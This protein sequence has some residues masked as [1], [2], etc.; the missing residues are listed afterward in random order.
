MFFTRI[1][2]R[3]FTFPSLAGV[4]QLWGRI[5]VLREPSRKP[6]CSLLESLLGRSLFRAWLGSASSG[7][8]FL[9]S[10]NPL[11]NHC[12]LQHTPY[13]D[14]HFSKP[15]WGRPAARPNSSAPRTLSET[16]A[17]FTTSLIATSTFLSLAGSWWGS[18]PGGGPK[19]ASNFVSQ[20]TGF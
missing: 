7:A 14:V 15:G 1:L 17:F 18:E 13:C 10:E 19:V 20:N 6:L 5:P 4:G 8:E 9:C 16:I 2:T 12:V 11:A 3:T